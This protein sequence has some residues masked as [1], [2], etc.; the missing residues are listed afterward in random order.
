ME[1]D[2]DPPPYA[3]DKE[4]SMVNRKV[5]ACCKNPLRVGVYVKL[6]QYA[7]FTKYYAFYTNAKEVPAMTLNTETYH[8]GRCIC[9]ACKMNSA[10]PL[11]LLRNREVGHRR[12]FWKSWSMEEIHAWF[13]DF[14]KFYTREDNPLEEIPEFESMFIPIPVSIKII[15]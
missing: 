2:P 3:R 13:R 6:E 4:C 5:C 15:L 9:L 14:E 8:K 1:F 12:K 10:K 7:A 11:D